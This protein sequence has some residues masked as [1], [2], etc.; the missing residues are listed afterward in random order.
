MNF[1]FEETLFKGDK[2]RVVL[3]L[4]SR[5]GSPEDFTKSYYLI[6]RS[7]SLVQ[8]RNLNP[9]SHSIDYANKPS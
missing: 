9:N 1:V 6:S 3:N 5:K 2:N 7:I 8:T 4:T